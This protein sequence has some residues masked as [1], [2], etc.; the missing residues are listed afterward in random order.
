M[1]IFPCTDLSVEHDHGAG[2]AG[3]EGADDRSPVQA[4]CLQI[5]VDI[6]RYCIDIGDIRR[7]CRYYIYLAPVGVGLHVGEARGEE[8]VAVV[9]P[10][11]VGVARRAAAKVLS[12][13][14]GDSLI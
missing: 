11:R 1:Q 2:R 6:R 12:E 7:Y 10:G 4:P 13:Q 3:G 9:D 8:D 5:C 14:C